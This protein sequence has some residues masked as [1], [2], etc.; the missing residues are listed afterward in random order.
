MTT[1]MTT[2]KTRSSTTRR[3]IPTRSTPRRHRIPKVIERDPM[4][5]SGRHSRIEADQPVRT[6][7]AFRLPLDDPDRVPEGYPVKANTKSGLYWPPGSAHTMRRA[8][9]SGSPVKN[10]HMPTGSS[11]DDED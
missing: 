11:A 6:R 10:S 9:K 4:T 7:T 8:P 5:D 3:K 1:T 2:K